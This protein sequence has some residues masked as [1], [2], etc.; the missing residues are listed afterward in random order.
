ME[1][2]Q[3]LT[4]KGVGTI[5]EQDLIVHNAG[6]RLDGLYTY[7]TSGGAGDIYVNEKKMKWK[8]GV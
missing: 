7:K 1:S 3:N 5:N 8:K 4:I 6:S 2:Y